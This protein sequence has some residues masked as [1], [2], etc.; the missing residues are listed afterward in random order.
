MGFT[1]DMV[2]R[3]GD[4]S[5]SVG[6]PE[7]EEKKARRERDLRGPCVTGRVFGEGALD[8]E[9]DVSTPSPV[10]SDA[11]RSCTAHLLL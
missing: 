3:S 8:A 4:S 5:G 11:G 1:A 6:V 9:R 10:V 7:R 2:S